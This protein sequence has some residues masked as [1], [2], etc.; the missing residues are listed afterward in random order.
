MFGDI[1]N[2]KTI[3]ESKNVVMDIDTTGNFKL[4]FDTN[5][6]SKEGFINNRNIKSIHCAMANQR[7][8]L[9]YCSYPPSE[10][11]AS[12][13]FQEN[14]TSIMFLNQILDMI[15]YFLEV[16]C[17]R[18]NSLCKPYNENIFGKFAFGN[19]ELVH[20]SCISIPINYINRSPIS[21]VGDKEIK[22][23]EK[24]R[25]R[26]TQYIRDMVDD[27]EFWDYYKNRNFSNIKLTDLITVN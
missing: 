8:T 23:Q 21:P 2:V 18:C 20:F 24:Y 14:R 15:L 16:R 19:N 6:L 25:N 3:V 22:L 7:A 5:T 9:T 4:L 1:L 17:Y 11:E 27:L 13:G 10:E 26:W 12:C